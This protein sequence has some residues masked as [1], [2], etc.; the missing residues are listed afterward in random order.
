[1]EDQKLYEEIEQYLL[2]QLDPQQKLDFESRMASNH[3][4]AQEVNTVKNLYT[5][6][7]AGKEQEV[8]NTLKQF[9]SEES[10]FP[11]KKISMATFS[12]QRYAVAASILLLIGIGWL[13]KSQFAPSSLQLFEEYHQVYRAPIVVRGSDQHEQW[14]QIREAYVNQEYQEVSQLLLARPDSLSTYV[15]QFY[16]GQAMLAQQDED[17]QLAI[18]AFERV[19][20]SDNDYR[21]Q[22]LWYLALTHLKQGDTERAKQKLQELLEE[23]GYQSENARDLLDRL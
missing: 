10:D 8:L 12:W 15:H 4:L 16:L 14:P 3:S 18:Q 22:S 17:P 13:I 9:R 2:D 19:L 1:M 7:R 5:I 6:V 23:S 11:G 21:V 20:A